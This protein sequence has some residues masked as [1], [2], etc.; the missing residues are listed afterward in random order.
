MGEKKNAGRVSV[1][2]R[3]SKSPLGRS[4]PSCEDNIKID[5]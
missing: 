3:D 5:S 4:V 2:K 1:V